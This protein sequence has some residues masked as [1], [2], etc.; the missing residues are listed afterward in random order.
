MSSL[1]NYF[2]FFLF[3]SN[4]VEETTDPDDIT[5]PKTPSYLSADETDD[6][7]E[8]DESEDLEE[9]ISEVSEVE[10]TLPTEEVRVTPKVI[11]HPPKPKTKPAW[12]P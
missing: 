8:D 2:V 12:R 7:S 9:V 11:R 1:N 10:I 5:P 3:H 4:K 6:D